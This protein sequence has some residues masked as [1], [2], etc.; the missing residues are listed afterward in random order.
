M[1][2]IN[3]LEN[4]RARARKV[5]EGQAELARQELD[6]ELKNRAQG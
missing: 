1:E 6:R 3:H 4:I 5:A 2:F